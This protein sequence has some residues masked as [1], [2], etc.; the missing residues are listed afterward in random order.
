MVEKFPCEESEPLSLPR[1]P[2]RASEAFLSTIAQGMWA[3]EKLIEAI[4]ST[5]KLIAI[6]YGQSRYNGELISNKEAW[7]KYIE[8]VYS[9]M[10]IYGKRPDLLI[11]RKED[12]V[13][14]DIP[15]DISERDEE[16][17]KDIVFKAVAGIECRSSSYYYDIYVKARGNEGK[18]LSITVKDED[19]ERL[20]K[21]RKTYCGSKPLYY[22]QLF[23]DKGFYISYD[24]I[25]KLINLRR[26][27]TRIRHYRFET[28]RT[29][30]K[31]THFI[32]MSH[33][34]EGLIAV[35]SPKLTAKSIVAWD[36]K[37]Y[38]IRM[39]EGGKYKLTDE[40]IKELLSL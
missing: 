20:N 37:V 14:L 34:K 38:A 1:P 3:E 40:F 10:S 9:Q 23:F 36:G 11:F 35:E 33:A 12:I 5:D 31:A 24:H 19:L 30:G 22:V 15:T 26:R 7:Q 16:D 32:G 25:L 17:I 2:A 4:N 6:R 39:P 27:G 8:R 29:T 28:D 21:W 13:D 18:E